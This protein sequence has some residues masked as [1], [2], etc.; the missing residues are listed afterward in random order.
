M[1]QFQVRSPLKQSSIGSSRLILSL[2][3]LYSNKGDFY[4]SVVMLNTDS[5][6]EDDIILYYYYYYYGQRKKQR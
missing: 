1:T 2:S 3:F 4:C 5:S 6:D